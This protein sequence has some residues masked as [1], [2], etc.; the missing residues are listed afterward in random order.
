MAE[1]IV[2]IDG[3]LIIQAINFLI[4]L[5]LINKFLFQPL[6]ELLEN[7]EK[8]I[9]NIHSEAEAL[10]LKAQQLLKEVDEILVKAKEEAK[11]LV[12][13]AVSEARREREKIISRAQEEAI[14]KIESAKQEIWDSFSREKKKLEKEAEKI[15]DEIVKKIF[16][17]VA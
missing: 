6:L 3:T 14:A 15:A 17:K 9:G 4:F 5:I 8:E 10:K 11:N 7:R 12:E 16:E 1:S 13:A 2:A